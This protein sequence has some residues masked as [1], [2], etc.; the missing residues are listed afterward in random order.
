MTPIIQYTLAAVFLFWAF[1][2]MAASDEDALAERCDQ[3]EVWLEDKAAGVPIES[4]LGLYTT[5]ENFKNRC[6]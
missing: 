6:F 2:Y 4:R 3:W 5:E 1:M